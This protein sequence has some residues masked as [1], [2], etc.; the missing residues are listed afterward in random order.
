MHK[1][2]SVVIPVF[3]VAEILKDCLETVKWADEIICVDMGSTDRTLEICKAYGARVIKNVP[4]GR[5]FDLNRKLGMENAKGDWILKIDSDDRLTKRLQSFIRNIIRKDISINGYNIY[6]KVF[7]FNKEIK[8]GFKAHRSHELRLFKELK[9]SYNPF[10]FHQLIGVEGETG[11]LTGEY[12]HFNSQSI[13]E[14]MRKMN[15]YTDLDAKKDF[16]VRRDVSFLHTIISPIYTFIKFYFLRFGLLDETYGLIVS[17]LYAFYN[18]F[19]KVKI[20]EERK[21]SYI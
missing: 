18:F 17:S 1:K 15:V 11:F 5:N 7:F 4:P 20:W 13:A 19:Y 16:I 2:L 21:K 8:Y 12:L 6:N 14:F 10:K 9:W 3:N